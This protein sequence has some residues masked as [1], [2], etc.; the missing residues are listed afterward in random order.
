MGYGDQLMATGMARGARAR[1]KRIAFGDGQKIL[2]DHHSAQI[3]RGNPNIAEP[4]SEGETDLEWIPFYRGNRIYN[5]QAGD[6][7]IWNP[8]FR[9]IPGDVHFDEQE[10]A[11]ARHFGSGFVVIEPNVPEFK[12]VAPNKQWPVARYREVAMRVMADGLRVVQFDH[13]GAV[14]IAGA[15]LVRSPTFR[16]GMAVLANAA[17]YIGAEGGLHHAAAA[18]GIPAVV[19]FGGFIPP[20]VTGYDTHTNL[21][22]GAEACGSLKA[23]EHC[24]R[25]MEAISVSDVMEAAHQHLK[26]AA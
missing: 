21:T 22:G 3:F 12:T 10:A 20:Q 23:C 26:V 17:L 8:D 5:R 6:R 19:L 1:G 16:H 25:A 24:K 11:F 15:R 4:G 9:A 7:W 2:W 18:V 13:G 14:K